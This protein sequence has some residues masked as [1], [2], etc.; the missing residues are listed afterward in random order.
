MQA[1][2][3]VDFDLRRLVVAA[4]HQARLREGPGDGGFQREGMNTVTVMVISSLS[5]SA[6][7]VL[8]CAEPAPIAPNHRSALWPLFLAFAWLRTNLL[9]LPF[10]SKSMRPSFMA[11]ASASRNAACAS[12]GVAY[13][14]P[15]FSKLF[16]QGRAMV[17]VRR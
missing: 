5:S 6:N 10:S 7:S 17:R 9:C 14:S 15:L 13:Q 11:D 4:L 8:F 12:V 2:H 3:A 16:I 1:D